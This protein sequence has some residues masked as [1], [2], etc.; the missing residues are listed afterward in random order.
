MAD[1][2]LGSA[3]GQIVIDA[4]TSGVDRANT[5]MGSLS[6]GSQSAADAADKVGTTMVVAGAAVAGG[7]G[8][9]VKTAADFEQELSGIKAVSGA[10]ADQ[11]QSIHDKAMQIGKDTAFGATE[12]AQAMSELAKAGLSVDDILGGAADATVA[13]AAATGVDMP[14]AATIASNAMNVFGLKASEMG[15]VVDSFS[16]AANASAIDVT[17]LGMSMQQVGAV[18]HL[19]GLSMKDTV[20]AIGEMGDAGIKGSDAGTSLKTMLMNLQP[21]TKKASDLM[22]ELGIITKDGSNQFYDAKGNVK[23]LADIQQVLQTALKGMSSEQK[24]AALQTLFGS[25][26]IR[27]AAVMAE[28]GAAGFQKFTEKMAGSGTAADQAKTRMDNVKGSLEQMKGSVE[29]AAISVGEALLPVVKDLTGWIG[30]LFDWFNALPGPVQTMTTYILAGAAAFLLLGGGALK[31][32]RSFQEIFGAIST[33]ITWLFRKN[34][35]EVESAAVSETSAIRSALAWAKSVAETVVL[36]TWYAAEAVASAVSSAAVWIAQ[37]TMAAARTAAAW[38]AAT[39][40]TIAQWVVMAGAATANALKVAAIWVAQT[41]AAGAAIAAQWAVA[42]A[43]TVAQWVIMS[44]SAVA[45]AAIVAGAWLLQN[46]IA[47][48]TSLASLAVAVATTVGGW[49]LMAGAAIINAA[50][51]AASWLIAFWPI[52]L[53][54]VIIAAIVVAVV[55]FWD[56]IVAAFKAAWEWIK[57]IMQGIWDAIKAAWDWITQSFMNAVAVI[58]SAMQAIWDGIKSVWDTVINFLRQIPG[59]IASVFS[60]AASW[61]VDAGRNILDGLWNGLKSIWNTVLGWVK[62]IGGWVINALG[63]AGSWLLGIGRNIV[64]GL[65]N[66]ISGAASWLWNKVKGWAMSIFD[67]IKSLFGIGSPSK[68]FRDEIGKWL[69]AGIAVGID[70]N[71]QD[72]IDAAKAMVAA[73]R[74]SVS[75]SSG[76]SAA[77]W[78]GTSMGAGNVPPSPEVAAYAATQGEGK[79]VNINT[80]IYNPTV[81]D[82]SD[83]EARRLRTLSALGAF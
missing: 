82:A 14:T 12:A 58:V 16:Q 25:D 46:G 7:L 57:T 29:T 13:L 49:L 62:G 30:S 83:S 48:A 21:Q 79:T 38:V 17:D 40:Q 67:G 10:T 26:A 74:D 60:S 19:A 6:K 42:V 69:P 23:S 64:E 55:M 9:A 5:A 4:D 45:Q 81:E 43:K 75:M 24:Q 73:T 32:I 27:A 15:G 37:T 78:D 61:L 8:L 36:W 77:F 65:W 66:G 70:K 44:A 47:V 41:I 63:D 76:G 56:Q 35:A 39:A 31:M 71:A 11:M 50:I 1:Y 33:L 80:N 2:S 20:V 22:S 54:V 53:I 18:A 72:A 59:W 51:I 34:V 52:A 68:L 28:N 3:H